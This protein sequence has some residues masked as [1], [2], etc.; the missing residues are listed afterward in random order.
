MGG[1]VAAIEKGYPQKQ[2]ADAA[3]RFQ[4]QVDTKKRTSVGVNKY[5]TDHAPVDILKIDPEVERKQT[6]RLQA[7]KQERNNEKV[8]KRLEE[9][10][11]AAGGQENLMPY[12]IECV[13]EYSTLQE[14]CDVFRDVFGTYRD[15]AML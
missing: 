3:Y 2:I 9:L 7:V 6:A 14:V 15:P 10:R 13:R 8:E 4:Q 1:M 12:I 11:R 5:V